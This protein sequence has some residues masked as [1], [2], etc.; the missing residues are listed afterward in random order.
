VLTV[1]IKQSQQFVT[2]AELRD[3]WAAADEGGFDSAWVFDHFAPMGP[4]R[5]GPVF[6][7]WTLLAAMAQAT[8][9]VR[10]GCLVTGN[11]Y[12]HPAILAKMAV[13]VDHLSGGRLEMGLGAGGDA[14]V[15]G[16]LG[17]PLP[18]APER[19]A[20]LA[21]A[22]R[23]LGGL[24][25]EPLTDSPGP[26]YPLARAEAEPKPVQRPGPPLWL[27]SAGERLGLRVVAEHADVWVTAQLPG[28]PAAEFG[29]LSGVL[30]GH[31]ATVGRDPATLR[32]AVQFRA[33]DRETT[34]R[35][36]EGY[37]RAGAT[38]LILMG[39]AEQAAELLPELRAL[40]QG[41]D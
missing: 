14:A 17:L 39:A 9:R 32:R 13:T 24:W 6:E 22:C 40:G 16:A 15:D 36:A 35:T 34:L 7:A 19:I 21:E 4:V 1:G 37:V 27:G 8:R 29:R 41:G 2:V 5:S 31:C 33:G 26:H 3:A 18:P 30:D 38:D 28:V 23:V 10:I 12:R 11:G 25:T 20:R